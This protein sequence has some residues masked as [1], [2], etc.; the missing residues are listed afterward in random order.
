MKKNSPKTKQPTNT[1]EPT[2]APK[3][4]PITIKKERL[5]PDAAKRRRDFI[6]DSRE[7]EGGIWRSIYG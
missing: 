1:P 2:P 4:T 6:E 7:I 3:N 5:P